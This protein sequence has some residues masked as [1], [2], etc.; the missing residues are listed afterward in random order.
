M[1]IRLS[2][3]SRGP[4]VLAA[5]AAVVFM[6]ACTQAAMKPKD[7][8]F[9]TEGLTVDVVPTLTAGTPMTDVTLPEAM[10]GSGDITYSVTPM[11]PGLAFN[12][13]TRVLGGTPTT[14]GT[15]PLTYTATTAGGD[16]ATLTLTVKVQSSLVGSFI[17]SWQ[18]TV[19]WYEDDEMVG[20]F[21]DTLTFTKSRY[22]MS[23]S[24]YMTG[25]TAVD[26]YWNHSGSWEA[27]DTTITRTWQD[28]HDDDDDDD[29]PDQ[30]VRVRKNYL[31]NE[32]RTILCVQRWDNP[33]EELDFRECKW[34]QGVPSPPPSNLLGTWTGIGD[35]DNWNI[36]ITPTQFTVSI[37][38][39]D[40]GEEYVFTLT[41]TY[42]VN[43]EELFIMLTVEDALHDGES[44]LATDEHWWQGLVSRWAFA[45]TDNPSRM[46]VSPHWEELE[47]IEQDQQWVDSTTYPDGN[48]WLTVEKQ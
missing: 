8:S 42:Q 11:V 43:H 10:G 16:E 19:G 15:F 17:G 14:P 6:A 7:L 12:P 23:R 44:I 47:W 26:H 13:A 40:D 41:G 38:A 39:D 24:H 30:R 20:T 5:V 28:D 31:W 1:T 22:V 25:I 27:T 46:V 34:H 4:A 37:V 32:D 18:S 2:V 3:I 21:T 48:Y 45:P 29:T 9:G 33:D 36:V 35:D